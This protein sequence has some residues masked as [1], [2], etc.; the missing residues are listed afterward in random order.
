MFGLFGVHFSKRRAE[1]KEKK[2]GEKRKHY[3]KL[4]PLQSL[5][6]C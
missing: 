4:T 5:Q 6:Q 2:G 1:K 3:Y